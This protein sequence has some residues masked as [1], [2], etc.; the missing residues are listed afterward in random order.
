MKI[1][2]HLEVAFMEAAKKHWNVIAV[3]PRMLRSGTNMEDIIAPFHYA[4]K[5]VT[6]ESVQSLIL[7]SK[8]LPTNLRPIHSIQQLNFYRCENGWTGQ[9]CDICV[10]L[11]GCLHGS[12]NGKPY[13]CQCDHGWT[14]SL[15]DQPICSEGCN[16]SNAHCQ[17]VNCPISLTFYL[18]IKV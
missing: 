8:I 14:G 1:V 9:N 16:L 4:Q 5:V 15:C 11:S 6:M 2:Y 10:K 18:V 17:M 12:C 3:L 13:E 7:A